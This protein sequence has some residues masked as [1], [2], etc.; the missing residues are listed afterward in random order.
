MGSLRSKFACGH[1]GVD[2]IAHWLV[3]AQLDVGPQ[4]RFLGRRE[5]GEAERTGTL[6]H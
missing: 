5:R 2:Y 6:G 1:E 4:N 3:N